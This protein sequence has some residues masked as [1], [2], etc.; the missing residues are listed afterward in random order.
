[1]QIT[2]TGVHIEVT[3]AIKEY[4]HEKYDVFRKYTKD[5]D[6]ARLS[7]ELSKTTGHRHQG[8]MYQVSALLVR[9]GKEKSL[10]T[11]SD[12]LYKSIDQMKDKLSRELTEGKDKELSLF[13]RGAHKIKN[14]VKRNR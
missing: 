11:V 12:D 13:K 7:V 9:K 2:I 8:D 4:V 1:M 10:E 6:T 3:Q 14:L 5:D